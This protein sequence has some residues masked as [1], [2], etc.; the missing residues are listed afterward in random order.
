MRRSNSHQLTTV[1]II[2]RTIKMGHGPQASVIKYYLFERSMQSMQFC[3]RVQSVCC[4]LFIR[5]SIIIFSTIFFFFFY[6][7][8]F[9]SIW[10]Y[11][12]RARAHTH[13]CS[14]CGAQPLEMEIKY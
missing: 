4:L 1:F 5:Q 14:H 9:L 11:G 7:L 13:T 2:F 12:A 10:S 6:S 3:H 8:F